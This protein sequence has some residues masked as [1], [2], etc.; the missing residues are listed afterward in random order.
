[1]HYYARSRST[2]YHTIFWTFTTTIA[3][4]MTSVNRLAWSFL[5]LWE[6]SF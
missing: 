6:Q 3:K 5:R 4:T 2:P 1:L